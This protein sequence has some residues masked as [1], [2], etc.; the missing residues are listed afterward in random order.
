MGELWLSIHISQVGK[1][2]VELVNTPE[3]ASM[4]DCIFRAHDPRFHTVIGD[5]PQVVRLAQKDY[6]FAH[7]VRKHFPSTA[8]CSG[9]CHCLSRV[10]S[11]YPCSWPDMQ[12]ADRNACSVLA[13]A[14]PGQPSDHQQLKARVG[15]IIAGACVAARIAQAVLCPDLDWQ[16][17]YHRPA[18]RA[19]N[20]LRAPYFSSSN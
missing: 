4:K 14:H 11:R 6:E 9:S 2:K 3:G 20:P 19:V 17:G 5:S 16:S 18:Y 8:A 12:P 13:N 7:E 1:Q 10:S 15:A